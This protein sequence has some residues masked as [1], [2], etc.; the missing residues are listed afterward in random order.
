MFLEKNFFSL[1]LHIFFKIE[2]T[3]N[4]LKSLLDSGVMDEFISVAKRITSWH[5]LTAYCVP[6]SVLCN[7]HV[8]THDNQMRYNI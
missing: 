5:V 4:F 3:P 2:I 7:L 8:W 6:D 1:Y